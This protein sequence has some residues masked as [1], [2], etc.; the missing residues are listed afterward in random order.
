[1]PDI[2]Y[3]LSKKNNKKKKK[4]ICRKRKWGKVIGF[5]ALGVFLAALIAES[6][7]YPNKLSWTIK[8][9]WHWIKECCINELYV[10]FK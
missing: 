2:D 8:S 1:M 9:D 5:F 7:D 4:K 10:D 3:S 6:I